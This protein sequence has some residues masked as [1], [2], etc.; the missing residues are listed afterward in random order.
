MI[1]VCTGRYWSSFDRAIWYKPR[2]AQYGIPNYKPPGTGWFTC[3]SPVRLL[4]NI[5]SCF[6]AAIWISVVA[7]PWI[8]S[9]GITI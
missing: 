8:Y 9:T 5:D 1:V 3:R 2:I 6:L 4:V 7:F